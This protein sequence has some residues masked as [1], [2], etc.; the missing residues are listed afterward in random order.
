MTNQ[1]NGVTSYTY[2]SRNRVL[3]LTN[4][5]KQVTQY[6][7]DLDSNV[8]TQTDANA[9][10]TTRTY[11]KRNQVLTIQT[12][13]ATNKIL[14]SSSSVYDPAGLLINITQDT[15]DVI[16]Y[17]YD[18]DHHLVGETKKTSKGAVVYSYVYTYDALGNRLTMD[19]GGVTTDYTYNNL[20]ELTRSVTKGSTNKYTYNSDGDLIETDEAGEITKSEYDFDNRLTK[21]TYPNG[22]TSEFV[23]SGDNR[24]LKTTEGTTATN[25]LYDGKLPIIERNA[26]NVTKDTYTNGRRYPGGIGGLI[27]RIR[28]TTTLSYHY[29][30]NGQT[31]VS[32]LTNDAGKVVE[33]YDYDAFGNVVDQTGTKTNTRQFQ[34]KEIDAKSGLI[35][36][37]ERWYDP[38]IGRWITPD[39]LGMI[40]GPNEYIYTLNSPVNFIDPNGEN[41]IEI[42]GALILGALA[43]Y[44]LIHAIQ[45]WYEAQPFLNALNKKGGACPNPFTDPTNAEKDQQELKAWA[46]SYQPGQWVS[47]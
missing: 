12:K 19:H 32:D 46:D 35:Y 34:T 6:T 16:S 38:T 36:F 25:Y 10:V 43:A 20:N 4:P 33:T 42:G 21:M 45:K 15:G 5:Q 3:S 40:D 24:R 17:I 2:D 37:G 13:N 26:S 44:E 8:L 41:L 29:V 27:S 22:T 1:D 30:H 23:Y 28:G 14:S 39:P 31:N 47:K 9:T 11:S 7:Y 18:G